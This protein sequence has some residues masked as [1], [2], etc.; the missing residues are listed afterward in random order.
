MR[1]YKLAQELGLS[2]K[3]VLSVLKDGG[4][5][6]AS[7][8]T[9]LSDEALAY[10]N[11]YY[12]SQKKSSLTK[13]TEDV[14]TEKD[15]TRDQSMA[16][17]EFQK[18]TPSIVKQVGRVNE[19][20]ELKNDSDAQKGGVT[21]DLE[22]QEL[23]E[24]ERVRRLLQATSYAGLVKGG[25][26]SSPR[27]RKRRRFRPVAQEEVKKEAVTD[28]T[29]ERSL[30]LFEVADLFNKPSGD[31][32]LL[33]L[34]KGMAC[35]RNYL[36]AV[37]MIKD[38]GLQLGITVRVKQP[39]VSVPGLEKTGAKVSSTSSHGV[40]RWPIVAV[41][42]HVDHGKTTLLDYIRKMN[43]AA[44]EKGGITQHLRAWEVES[45][46]GKIV[47]LD[48]PGHEAFSFIRQQGSKITDIVI[49]VV[50]AD[51][52]VKPQTVEALKQAQAAGVHIVVAI[53]KIDKASPSAIE[54]VKRQLSQYGL[55]PE[56]WGGQTVFVPISAKTGQGVENLL[57]MVTL[58]AQIMDLRAEVDVPAKA[59]VLESH[60]EKGFGPVAT[61]ICQEGTLK[62]GDY[63][64]CGSSSG[65]VRILIN[66]N[67]KKIMQAGPA[68][69]V[70]VVGFDNFSG[71]GDTLSVVSH[72]EHNRARSSQR[73][74]DIAVQQP[75]KIATSH[76][77]DASKKFINL[78]IKTDTRG[79]KEAVMDSI[80]KLIKQH[81]DIKCPINIVNAAI[82]D[83]SE[84][85]I[86]LAHNTQA[87]I[88]GLHT[89]VE[90]NAQLFAKSKSIAIKTYQIIYELIDELQ[91]LLLSKKEAV[92]V[93]NK[94]GEAVVKKVFDIK[95]VGVI[96]G[97]YMRDGVLARGN[98]VV[99][100]RNGKQ[101]GEGKVSTLQ[102][103]RKSVKEI[104]AGFECGFTTDGF[105]EWQEG[106][107]VLCYA[108]TKVE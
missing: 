21:E 91:Q 55:M 83:I 34:K 87:V 61:V 31:L 9:I 63:F 45:V 98:K 81:K 44:T 88:L 11:K 33:L 18:H 2:S 48:T 28:I 57:E 42:G 4:Y 37:D 51:D 20:V 43:V 72:H 36:L 108:E 80:E 78:I 50:A 96:A 64:V 73:G 15:A 40:S 77:I 85:D 6:V 74:F 26:A 22:L 7:H 8:M 25:V 94:V 107:T 71:I 17:K 38:L 53:N 46:H 10:L 56:E 76:V 47:F 92:F 3:D 106:D 75:A 101:I 27:K 84:S 86:E 60:I 54:T 79:S 16:K 30:P 104:H 49:L 32:V 95:G 70:Q 62:I 29:V 59:F 12:S 66:S 103:E 58:Q 13:T 1:V 69:P 100:I 90:K 105:S 19:S 5:Q 39:T 52:G 24:Q 93:W 65:K 35:N 97:C 99:C 102:R 14:A 67:G 89:K 82:G 23:Q 41:M 68:I